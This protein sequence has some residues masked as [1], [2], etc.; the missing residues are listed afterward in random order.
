MVTQPAFSPMLC[1]YFSYLA[2]A[3]GCSS[4]TNA[5]GRLHCIHA[6]WGFEFLGRCHS[7]PTYSHS[8]DSGTEIPALDQHM[9]LSQA[10][11]HLLGSPHLALCPSST[12]ALSSDTE[13]GLTRN[14][15]TNYTPVQK[16]PQPEGSPCFKTLESPE[17]HGL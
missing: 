11:P 7:C 1:Q 13:Q 10:G 17:C 4:K 6:S 16:G 12:L 8:P 14:N 2:A 15:V 5:L 3:Q 9:N